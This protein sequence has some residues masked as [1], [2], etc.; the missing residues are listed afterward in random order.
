MS[1]SAWQ[2]R[3]SFIKMVPV[4]NA[5]AAVRFA[6]CSMNQFPLSSS[7]VKLAFTFPFPKK[8]T[9]VPRHEKLWLIRRVLVVC[10]G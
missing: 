10:A 7:V 2:A 8:N 9:D 4:K 6:G 1:S 5:S 3:E